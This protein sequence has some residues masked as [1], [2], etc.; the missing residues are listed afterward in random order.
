MPIPHALRL[1][2]AFLLI[3][4]AILKVHA[5]PVADLSSAPSP[6]PGK[7]SALDSSG[8][9]PEHLWTADYAEL[10]WND[11]GLVVT[12]PARWDQQ[13]WMYAGL[14]VAGIGA[15]AAFDAT[16]RDHV[17]A[18]RSAGEDRFF[19]QYQNLGST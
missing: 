12:A 17:Q 6:N 11:T 13:D 2:F 9:R 16:V 15:S 1:R 5:D 19:R 18:H 4:S 10:L 14:S 8:I 3:A 7:A